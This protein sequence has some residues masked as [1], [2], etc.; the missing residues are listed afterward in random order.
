MMTFT[1]KSLLLFSLAILSGSG[2]A[3]ETDTLWNKTLAQYKAANLWAPKEIRTQIE[4]E[5]KDQPGKTAYIK[6]TLN[7]WEK[8]D[9]K[10]ASANTDSN[11]QILPEQKKSPDAINKILT[12]LDEL[13][14]SLLEGNAKVR[15]MDN[16]VL[17][18]KS[19][20]VF[21]LSDDG[22]GSKVIIKIWANP[23]TACIVKMDSTMHVTLYA[24]ASFSTRYTEPGK[25]GLCFR[26]QMQGN[27]DI[28]V[29]FKKAKMSIKQ[30]NSD[31]TLKPAN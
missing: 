28:Q 26:G 21:Q 6:S 4:A 11:W 16:D 3:A 9:P 10:Y 27:I 31:W 5:R 7:G 25:D 19:L 24:D 30:N 2:L 22:A 15:R 18:G 8:Q 12:G 23:D 17:D 1:R 29:P 14:S 20:A 13:K